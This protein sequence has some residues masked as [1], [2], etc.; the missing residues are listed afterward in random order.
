M[1]SYYLAL[2]ACFHNVVASSCV[3]FIVLEL[4]GGAWGRL[5]DPRGAAWASLGHLGGATGHGKRT[6]YKTWCAMVMVF[7]ELLIFRLFYKVF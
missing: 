6:D 7:W 2:H 1:L 5:G 3:I 4:L